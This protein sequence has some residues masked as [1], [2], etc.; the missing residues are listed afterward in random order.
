MDMRLDRRAAA[1]REHD[2]AMTDKTGPHVHLS[3]RLLLIV[4]CSPTRIISARRRI[5]ENT[6]SI[7]S[8]GHQFS[9]AQMAVRSVCDGH[10][11]ILALAVEKARQDLDIQING[12]TAGSKGVDADSVISRQCWET[13][14][15]AV[16]KTCHASLSCSGPVIKAVKKRTIQLIR[17]YSALCAAAFLWSLFRAGIVLNTKSHNVINLAV[18]VDPILIDSR[19]T[20]AC[21]LELLDWA[22]GDCGNGLAPSSRHPTPATKP[23]TLI[24]RNLNRKQR[25]DW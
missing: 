21:L 24:R 6:T 2:F 10:C 23:T 22:G 25:K 15:F 20:G 17:G 11:W 19:E 9:A 3:D 18:H 5:S 12:R 14:I 4:F 1:E 7:Q 8:T 16:M 13:R